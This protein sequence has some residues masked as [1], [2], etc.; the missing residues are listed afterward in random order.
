MKNELI[1]WVEACVLHSYYSQVLCPTLSQL[2]IEIAAKMINIR[3]KLQKKII[4][5]SLGMK[6]TKINNRIK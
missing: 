5:H 6:D 1:S 3:Q 4:I 2:G